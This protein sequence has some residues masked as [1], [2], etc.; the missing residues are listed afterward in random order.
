MP[1][2][3]ECPLSGTALQTCVTPVCRVG[4][5]TGTSVT[6]D[7]TSC[8]YDSDGD[9][10]GV[11]PGDRCS[12]GIC[13]TS[14]DCTDSDVP[15][16]GGMDAPI[17]DGGFD[18]GMDA[19][20]GRDAGGPRISLHLNEVDWVRSSGSEF[21]EVHNTA[22]TGGAID[23]HGIFVVVLPSC[24]PAAP[25]SPLTSIG[26]GGYATA[27]GMLPND[28]FGVALIRNTGTVPE[29]VDAVA[30]SSGM[31]IATSCFVG[32]TTVSFT[33]QALSDGGN[34]ASAGHRNNAATDPWQV[35]SPTAG[36]ANSCP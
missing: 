19:P 23:D 13:S 11:C 18:A 27:T 12:F 9:P 21:V 8:T 32:G 4:S 15:L 6:M 30:F 7:T 26:P 24:M 3:G 2:P 22:P 34:G 1:L 29:V 5:C 17:I 31:S 14:G 35:C 28:S 16:D 10:C 36:A 25:V 20:A 33:T